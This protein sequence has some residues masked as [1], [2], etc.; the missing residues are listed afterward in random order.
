MDLA[1]GLDRISESCLYL[2]W[3]SVHRGPAYGAPH[4]F[5]PDEKTLHLETLLVSSL[6]TEQEQLFLRC[7]QRIAWSFGID[8]TPEHLAVARWQWPVAV[9]KH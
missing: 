5:S 8:L 9:P 3:L 1:V 6:A 4:G 7:C 2:D